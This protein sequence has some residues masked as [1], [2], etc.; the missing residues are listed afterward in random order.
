MAYQIS[1]QARVSAIAALDDDRVIGDDGHLPW[2]IPED[3]RRFRQLTMHHPVIM[4][5][6][7][8]ESIG[9]PL[10]GR[11][12]IVLTRS[13]GFKASGCTVVRSLNEALA[14]A[15][16]DD[17]NEVFIA[18]GEAVYAEALAHCDRLYLTLVRGHFNGTVHFP[19]YSAFSKVV[20][21]SAHHDGAHSY[22]FLVLEK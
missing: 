7:T 5:R 19:E 1:P 12:T 4:G 16:L 15:R 20:E 17:S 10:E 3:S 21:K 6:K 9:K 22:E 8:Y 13:R 18:G 11:H 2:R 14:V